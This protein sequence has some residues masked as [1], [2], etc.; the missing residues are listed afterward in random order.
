MPSQTGFTANAAIAA[1]RFPLLSK[2]DGHTY[3][4]LQSVYRA[5]NLDE[6]ADECLEK[7]RALGKPCEIT[8]FIRRVSEKEL[9]LLEGAENEN[10]SF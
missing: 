1:I 9:R 2:R 5:L 10:P 3:C 7:A 8:R 4:A 6:Q